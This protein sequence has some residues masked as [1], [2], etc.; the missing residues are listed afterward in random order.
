MCVK[1][2]LPNS[3]VFIWV[4][5]T[6][7]AG[8]DDYA[9]QVTSS[10]P[11]T[12]NYSAKFRIISNGPGIKGTTVEPS[13]TRTVG[14]SP[15][16]T[17][18]IPTYTGAE[19]TTTDNAAAPAATTESSGAANEMKLCGFVAAVFVAVAGGAAVLV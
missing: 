10:D 18:I 13:T 7:L 1:G 5:S 4:P 17:G 2:N 8:G 11:N 6:Q 19:I 15:L 9:I 14:P 12:S 3:G 16:H